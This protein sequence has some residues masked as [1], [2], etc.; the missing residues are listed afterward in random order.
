MPGRIR[1]FAFAIPQFFFFLSFNF[2]RTNFLFFCPINAYPFSK[3][4]CNYYTRYTFSK[5]CFNHINTH[6]H[7]NI[8]T[9]IRSTD[10][11]Q[12]HVERQSTIIEKPK[13]RVIPSSTATVNGKQNEATMWP[14]SDD[15]DEIAIAEQV[16]VIEDAHFMQNVNRASPN[17]VKRKQSTVLEDNVQSHPLQS[18]PTHAPAESKE[19]RHRSLLDCLDQN[20]FVESPNKI[21]RETIQSG[22][23]STST[24]NSVRISNEHSAKR[25]TDCCIDIDSET[26]MAKTAT[27]VTTTTNATIAMTAAMASTTTNVTTETM[28]T[29]TTADA[30]DTIE[31]LHIDEATNETIQNQTD[32]LETLHVVSD[33]GSDTPSSSPDVIDGTP[34]KSEPFYGSIK[35]Q[36]SLLDFFK[37]K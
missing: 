37:A 22:I 26:A 14:S 19:K 34:P 25:N 24:A 23:G 5:L 32:K 28:L 4:H 30:N 9:R 12:T 36:R 29:M 7:T 17:L 15:D 3:Q 10:S 20:Y 16:Q 21:K 2:V 18:V 33:P 31:K 11:S 1:S 13:S 6:K 8:L 35:T 27:N